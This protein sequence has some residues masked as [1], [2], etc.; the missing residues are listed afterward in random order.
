VAPTFSHQ[1]WYADHPTQPAIR[2][3]TYL[4]KVVLPFVERNYPA[5]AGAGGRLLLGFSK[6]GR[7]A[8]SLLLRHPGVF[9]R[10]AA[11]DAPWMLDRPNRY[12]MADIFGTQE[13]FEKYRVTKL[14]EQRA[15]DLRMAKRLV[16][17]G[18][19]NFRGHHQKAHKLMLELR[20]GHEYRDGPARAHEWGSGWL[21]EAVGL[22]VAAG[23]H[24][25]RSLYQLVANLIPLSTAR[26]RP[27]VA[28]RGGEPPHEGAE[29]GFRW[30]VTRRR[31]TAG[32]CGGA[33]LWGGGRLIR[34]PAS[35]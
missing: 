5:Q 12:G 25:G 26:H 17:L 21:P 11:W 31:A 22:L 14:L 9:G 18:Y 2:Q 13:N 29:R 27:Q 6:S 23:G 1:P 24:Q 7:G 15:G 30:F 34:R 33:C 3:E 16:L 4:R 35:G 32:I 19:G 8:F 10:A 20:I 28:G